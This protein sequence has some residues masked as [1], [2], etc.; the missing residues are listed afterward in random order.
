MAAGSRF[1]LSGRIA[2]VTGASRGIGSA[3]A[4]ALAE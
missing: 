4:E 1:D 2:L 3:I